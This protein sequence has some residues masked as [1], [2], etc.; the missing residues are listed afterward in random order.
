[1]WASR[2]S[3]YYTDVVWGRPG[4]VQGYGPGKIFRYL[5]KIYMQGKHEK[6]Q[7]KALQEEEKHRKSFKIWA[8]NCYFEILHKTR[9]HIIELNFPLLILC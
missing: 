5:K 6:L 8:M 9:L 1:M 2:D 7:L 4:G 3:L